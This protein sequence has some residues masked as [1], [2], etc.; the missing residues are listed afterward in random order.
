[1]KLTGNLDVTGAKLDGS[2][3]VTLLI[4]N[5]EVLGSLLEISVKPE[6]DTGILLDGISDENV[7]LLDGSSDGLMLPVNGEE[8]G[9]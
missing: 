2:S 7:T 6:E 8:L 9:F 1:M 3:V 4:D 5:I